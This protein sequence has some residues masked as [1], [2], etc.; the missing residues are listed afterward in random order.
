MRSYAL[1]LSVLLGAALLLVQFGMLSSSHAVQAEPVALD[2][3]A[4]VEAMEE[5]AVVSF[6]FRPEDVAEYL[7]EAV[8][9]VESGGRANMVGKAGERGIMQIKR[10]TWGHVTRRMNGQ[11]IP[12]DRAFDP[13]LN[14]RVGRAYLAEIQQILHANRAKWKSDERSLL[15]ACYNA[16]PERVKKAGYDVRRLPKSVQCYVERAS[17]LHDYYLADNAPMVREMLL[18]AV[19]PSTLSDKRG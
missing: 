19:D 1:E 16:G 18:T 17:A 4:E 14:R 13:E 9:Q 12:F 3:A 7:V 15:L 6:E 5:E 2:Y 11:P 10:A 8:I